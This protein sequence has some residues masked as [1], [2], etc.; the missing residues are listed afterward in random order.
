MGMR[1]GSVWCL[2][3]AARTGHMTPAKAP[4]PPRP[5]HSVKASEW[6]RCMLVLREARRHGELL[7]DSACYTSS[8]SLEL[9]F[10]S[11]D[12]RSRATSLANRNWFRFHCSRC[13]FSTMPHHPQSWILS[14]ACGHRGE[15]GTVA[16]SVDRS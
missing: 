13:Q 16:T 6:S 8:G 11:N 2:T 7:E 15:T 12:C 4:N 9:E 1:L 14:S 5:S 10:P 3:M